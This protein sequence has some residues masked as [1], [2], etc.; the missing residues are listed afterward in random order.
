[1]GKQ[2][3][4]SHTWSKEDEDELI[5]AVEASQPLLEHYQQQGYSKTRWWDTVAGRLAPDLL[6]TGGACSR[7]FAVMRSRGKSDDTVWEEIA[8][9]VAT[10]ERE[11]QETIYD[12]V[13][14]IER[15]VVA[16]AHEWGVEE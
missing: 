10:F 6:V 5:K 8:T 4:K 7:H 1:M 9:R 3:I 13:E 11:L 15:L 14:R 2:G 12:K 16:L